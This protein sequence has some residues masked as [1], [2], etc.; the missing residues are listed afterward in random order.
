MSTKAPRIKLKS[1]ERTELSDW[2]KRTNISQGL[3]L[4]A[5][6][7]LRLNE[8]ERPSEIAASLGIAR[9]TVY[10][11]WYRFADNGVE[12]LHDSPRSGRPTLI[13]E[14]T[15]EKVLKMTCEQIPQESSHWSI[16][17]MSEYAQISTWQV[18]QIWDAADLKPHRLKMFKIS[19]DPHFAEKVIDVVGL[20]MN[21]NP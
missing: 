2:L 20:Y 4:R 17:L 12:A 13:D 14:R 11:W 1:A 19:N 6:I 16:A 10:K 5:R 9:K 15:I 21:L 3:A 8:G 18:R 7:I